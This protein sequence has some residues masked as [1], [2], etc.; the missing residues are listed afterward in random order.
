AETGPSSDLSGKP[1]KVLVFLAPFPELPSLRAKS[2]FERQGAL[3]LWRR[4][5]GLHAQPRT[6][7]YMYPPILGIEPTIESWELPPKLSW[8]FRLIPTGG[9]ED[10]V[11]VRRIWCLLRGP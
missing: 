11:G 10:I 2:S 8:D 4:P 7:T 1:D 9:T 5:C 6:N 3:Q